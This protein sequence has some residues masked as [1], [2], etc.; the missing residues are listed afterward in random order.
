MHI[1]GLCITDLVSLV[2]VEK[3]AEK[4]GKGKRN[5]ENQEEW[6]W[7]DKEKKKN[8]EDGRQLCRMDHALML[9]GSLSADL[10]SAKG[11]RTE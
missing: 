8:M 9:H 5:R 1:R 7:N 3:G 6:K 4:A 11:P 10:Q 2:Q